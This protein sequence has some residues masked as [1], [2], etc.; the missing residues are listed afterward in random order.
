MATTNFSKIDFNQLFNKISND[1]TGIDN[2]ITQFMKDIQLNT[3]G[4]DDSKT[5]KVMSESLIKV[6]ELQ[7]DAIAVF[8]NDF[9]PGLSD[10]MQDA[11]K[12]KLS[13]TPTPSVSAPSAPP[14][15]SSPGGMTP[16]GS[17]S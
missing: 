5:A 14:I 6:V 11:L 16:G 17:S 8:N 13:S 7:R 3:H 2:Q 10:L 15:P 9:K 12:G 4:S 1:V